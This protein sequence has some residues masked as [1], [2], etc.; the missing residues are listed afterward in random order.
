MGVGER[1]VD[2]AELEGMA[3]LPPV[4]RDHVR[5]RGDAGGAPK[6][7]H[8]FAARVTV[9]G[10]AGILRVGE[11]VTLAAAEPDRLLERPGPVGIEGHP[12]P[13]ETAGDRGD[14][15]HLFLAAQDPAFE[16]EVIEA[17]PRVGGL[18]E[19]HDLL[20]GERLLM[21]EPEPVVLRV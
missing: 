10:A 20:G 5:R 15:F 13:R 19:T 18:G 21:P 7:R 6:F 3:E 9:L 2:R 11:Q 4:G 8:H 1:D 16:L 14:R 12:R 17:V